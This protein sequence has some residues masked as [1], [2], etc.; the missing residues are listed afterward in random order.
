MKK[1]MLASVVLLVVSLVSTVCFGVALGAQG[2]RALFGQ[3]GPVQDWAQSAVEWRDA[4]LYTAD[5]LE[6]NENM[7]LFSRESEPLPAAAKLEIDAQVGNILLFPSETSAVSV[8]LEQWSDRKAPSAA[9]TL[10]VSGN[11]ISLAADDTLDG[12]VALLKVYLP[13][14]VRSVTAKTALGSISF[15]KVSL[16]QADLQTQTGGIV[17]ESGG[18]VQTAS[19]YSA[20]GA[21]AV[22]DAFTVTDS[23]TLTNDCGDVELGLPQ[24]QPFT[25]HYTVETG[26]VETDAELPAAWQHSVQTAGSRR[27]GSLENSEAALPHA[28]YQVQIGVG[29]LELDYDTILDA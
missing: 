6:E 22:S 5:I 1:V 23:L 29:N 18:R 3:S 24:K 19:V 20:V 17:L 21:I 28:R 15:G 2:L 13:Q 12:T 14:E 27:T 4:V 9:Y 8:V 26:T 16:T 11:K 7:R 10:S 25:L